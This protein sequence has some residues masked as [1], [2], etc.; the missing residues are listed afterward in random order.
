MKEIFEME[1]I[2]LIINYKIKDHQIRGGQELQV[3]SPDS[4]VQGKQNQTHT[5][6]A[7]ET[8]FQIS[9]R[10]GVSVADLQ[11]QNGLK[12]TEIKVGQRIVIVRY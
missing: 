12:G 5:V 8:L 4:N 9:R 7:G 11:Q 3:Q 2:L 6:S 1:E 10:Y